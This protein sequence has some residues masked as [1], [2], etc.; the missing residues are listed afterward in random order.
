MTELPGWTDYTVTFTDTEHATYMQQTGVA[1]GGLRIMD[2]G[3]GKVA[4]DQE[5]VEKLL[6]QPEDAD[7][8]I[9]DSGGGLLLWISGYSYT[10]SPAGE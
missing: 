10:V 1:L 6:R 3:G 8:C 9:E 7:G 5:A 4:L 2:M